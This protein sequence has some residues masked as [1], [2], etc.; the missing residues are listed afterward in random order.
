MADFY[1]EFDGI[2]YVQAAPVFSIILGGLLIWLIASLV[3][4][5]S[6]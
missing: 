3:L 5:P 6:N 2:G 1:V 4:S